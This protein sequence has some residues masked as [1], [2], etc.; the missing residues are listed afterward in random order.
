VPASKPVASANINCTTITVYYTEPMNCYRNM[1]EFGVL[2]KIL[3]GAAGLDQIAGEPTDGGFIL[4][5]EVEMRA[6]QEMQNRPVRF[7]LVSLPLAR[8]SRIAVTRL[9]IGTLRNVM[10]PGGVAKR[11]IFGDGR[12]Q[13]IH[14]DAAIEDAKDNAA[15]RFAWSG[16]LEATTGLQRELLQ[17]RIALIH[18]SQKVDAPSATGGRQVDR[19]RS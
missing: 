10:L 19:A 12:A 4:R 7:S 5:S 16:V 2:G 15:K 8:S 3:H 13:P 9:Q 6:D 11:P 17:K 1:C 18:L 14:A